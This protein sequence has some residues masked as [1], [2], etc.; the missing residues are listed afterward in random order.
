[1][2]K[3]YP[4]G[5]DNSKIYIELFKYRKSKEL[6]RLLKS[7]CLSFQPWSISLFAIIRLCRIHFRYPFVNPHTTGIWFRS[8]RTSENIK[9]FPKIN[10][11]GDWHSQGELFAKFS[12]NICYAGHRQKTVGGGGTPIP[13]RCTQA[14][15]IQ[16]TVL[17]ERRIK[18]I[19]LDTQMT[20]HSLCSELWKR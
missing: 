7:G 3:C 9:D 17:R 15:V 1:M 2:S 4:N 12:I 20:F 13:I 8:T 19:S 5:A 16:R 6:F 14:C 18:R 11:E 10:T